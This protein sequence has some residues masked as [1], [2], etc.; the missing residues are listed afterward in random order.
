M[1]II[2]IINI[3][4]VVKYLLGSMKSCDGIKNLKHVEHL[5]TFPLRL[6]REIW[7]QSKN[8][9]TLFS[10]VILFCFSDL[11]LHSGIPGKSLPAKP[12]PPSSEP[13]GTKS[14]L[15]PT[16]SKRKGIQ[17]H[18]LTLLRSNMNDSLT[19]FWLLQ[20]A[21]VVCDTSNVRFSGQVCHT[22]CTKH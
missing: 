19:C 13:L 12:V 21:F 4:F 20:T 9:L 22:E 16:V 15:N 8:C 2:F 11:P 18:C 17:H 6:L 7:T 1:N 3:Q 5:M 10:L 14:V